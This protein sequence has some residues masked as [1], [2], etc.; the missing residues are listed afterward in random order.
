VIAVFSIRNLRTRHAVVTR[1]PPNM[2]ALRRSLF[3]QFSK[4]PASEEKLRPLEKRPCCPFFSQTCL[5]KTL[6]PGNVR[7]L[8]LSH[9]LPV[10]VNQCTPYRGRLL[11][12]LPISSDWLKPG[13]L[14]YPHFLCLMTIL[15]VR[16]PYLFTLLLK[17][18][19]ANYNV[20]TDKQREKTNKATFVIKRIIIQLVLSRQSLCGWKENIHSFVLNTNNIL[21]IKEVIL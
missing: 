4:F 10:T 6:I 2:G 11:S 14:L 20:S 17:R 1:N 9:F 16:C 15:F 19:E 7:S 12:I 3:F 18:P 13:S 5:L 21:I 8:S